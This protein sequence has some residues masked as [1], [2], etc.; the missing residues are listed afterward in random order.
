[1]NTINNANDLGR[2]EEV[3]NDRMRAVQ[4]INKLI[5]SRMA[6]GREYS[7]EQFDESLQLFVRECQTLSEI[8]D[9]DVQMVLTVLLRD[10][11]VLNVS[12]YQAWRRLS[13]G[14]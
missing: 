1:M 4:I 10:R 3:M 7:R 2:K 5:V 13:K 6:L 11:H 9:E 14:A 12:S 8:S